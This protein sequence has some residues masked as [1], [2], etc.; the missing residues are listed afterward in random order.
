MPTPNL[1]M[2][3]FRSLPADD[4]FNLNVNQISE[5]LITGGQDSQFGDMKLWDDNNITALDSV[6]PPDSGSWWDSFM[7]GFAGGKDKE[8]SA[9]G[10]WGAPVTNLASSALQAYMGL[11][12]LGLAEDTLDFQKGAFSK[13]FAAQQ[14]L[15]NSQLSDR[16]QKRINRNPNNESVAD[17]M[18]K[19]GV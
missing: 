12:Q 18:A 1:A 2:N 16:Q 15:T 7:S 3:A 11:E 17:Y 4:P 9:W 5:N 8:G 10:G 19:W 14:K 6:I 13:Q